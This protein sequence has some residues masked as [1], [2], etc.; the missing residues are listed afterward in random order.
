[1]RNRMILE[2]EFWIWC[3]VGWGELKLALKKCT[4]LLCLEERGENSS[5]SRVEGN[6][7]TI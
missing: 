5:P 3:G 4:P 1:M 7:N 6:R 2:A